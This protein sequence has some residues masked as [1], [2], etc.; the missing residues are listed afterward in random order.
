[1][2]LMT[3]TRFAPKKDKPIAEEPAAAAPRRPVLRAIP[4]APVATPHS[5]KGPQQAAW[6]APSSLPKAGVS[7]PQYLR[8]LDSFQRQQFSTETR[9]IVMDVSSREVEGVVALAAK[10]RGRYL[11]KLLDAAG[12]GRV[13]VSET[14]MKEIQRCREMYEE[15]MRGID[16][17]KLALNNGEI[18][19]PGMDRP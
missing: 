9:K 10:L 13:A 18:A 6:L 5:T 12:H 3:V 14:Q 19:I 2:S 4:D 11:A 17:L 1:M 7:V 16:E 15:A 8:E